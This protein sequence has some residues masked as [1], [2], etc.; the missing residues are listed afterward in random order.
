MQPTPFECMCKNI[1]L[2]EYGAVYCEKEAKNRVELL[3]KKTKR[4][5]LIMGRYCGIM[6]ADMHIKEDI[7]CFA[8][9]VARNPMELRNFAIT[10]VRT[11]RFRPRRLWVSRFRRLLR[12]WVSIS[13]R[14]HLR[15]MAI[16]ILRIRASTRHLVWL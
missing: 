3:A 5:V 13:P 15:L 2:G 8:T 4:A 1:Y 7:S 9:N 10:A 11:F 12:L 14:R 16:L 6:L